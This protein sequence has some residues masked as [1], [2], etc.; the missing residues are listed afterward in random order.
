MT[1]RRGD[2][3][4]GAIISRLVAAGTAFG[5]DIVNVS[6]AGKTAVITGAGSGIG[7]A[8]VL[9]FLEAGAAGVVAVDR[10]ADLAEMLG[11][12]RPAEHLS[13]LEAVRGDV[14]TEDAAREFTRVALDRFGG[15]DVLINNAAVSVV[16]PLHEHTPEEW[17]AVIN[18]NVRA[19]YWA[20]RHVIPVMIRSGGGVI[21]NAGSISGEVGLPAQ[22][23]YAASKGAVHQMTRQMAVEYAPHR[24][25]VNAVCCG[26]VDT[27]LVRRSA[28]ESG[29]PDAFWAILRQGH[30]IGRVATPQEVADFYVYLASDRATFF[31][32]A[33]V[34]MDGGYTAR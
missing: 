24:I 12:D 10:R 6:L 19:I 17:D 25:R 28:E 20:A 15:L 5:D 32:G 26:T 29:D 1:P 4:V 33:L 23:A 21:L 3:G 2:R 31:T 13:R 11:V 8:T 30:P 7:R 18:T 16:K 27:P 14:A 34:M 9:K 22:G